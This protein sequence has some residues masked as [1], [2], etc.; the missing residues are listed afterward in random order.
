MRRDRNVRRRN[1]PG[2]AAVREVAAAPA[3]VAD[4]VAVAEAGRVLVEGAALR[5]D[6]VAAAS[7]ARVRVAR[8]AVDAV[9]AKVVTVMADAATVEASSS[10]T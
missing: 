6:K 4:A 5:A 8:V 10:R 1:G 2:L 9:S 3:V 7:A